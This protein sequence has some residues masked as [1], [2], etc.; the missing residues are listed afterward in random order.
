[1]K[2]DERLRTLKNWHRQERG[3]VIITNYEM[4]SRSCFRE[5]Q[6]RIN[7]YRKYLID[8]GPSLIIADEGHKFKSE[9]VSQ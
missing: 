5:D 9:D 1:M 8:P 2:E 3:G 7:Q 4:I 6:R